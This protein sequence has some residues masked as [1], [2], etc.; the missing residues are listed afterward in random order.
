MEY[1]LTKYRDLIASKVTFYPSGVA[2]SE[3]ADGTASLIVGPFATKGQQ[4]ISAM[5]ST[6]KYSTLTLDVQNTAFADTLTLDSST[7]INAMQVGAT[8]EVDFG[9]KYGGFVAKDQYGRVIDMTSNP[10]NYE[11][12]PIASGN[13]T[14][15]G[16]ACGGKAITISATNTA[17]QRFG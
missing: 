8:Q 10:E 11:V 17:G 1:Q 5:T 2:L 6:G 4:M 3:N 7:L 16:T 15:S 14:A 9:W 13:V 12:I